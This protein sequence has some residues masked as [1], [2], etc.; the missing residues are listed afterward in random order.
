MEG[1]SFPPPYPG[2]YDVPALV[3]DV[4]TLGSFTMTRCNYFTIEA[5]HSVEDWVALLRD[6]GIPFLM[7]GSNPVLHRPSL[8]SHHFQAPDQIDQL[9]DAIEALPG[10]LVESASI[11]IPNHVFRS[12]KPDLKE[13]LKQDETLRRGSV[14]RISYR[15]FQLAIQFRNEILTTGEFNEGLTELG[16]DAV[17]YSEEETE[18]FRRWSK[19]QIEEARDIYYK[20]KTEKTGPILD[21]VDKKGNV[22]QG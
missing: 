2:P 16:G 17:Q 20:R 11:W 15:L 12:G 22:Q 13:E 21:Y 6:Q 14:W 10:L 7:V 8:K 9:F 5:S 4:K 18:A 19:A 1:P 3:D